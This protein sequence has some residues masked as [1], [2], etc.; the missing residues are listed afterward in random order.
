MLQ[1]DE[2]D[3]IHKVVKAGEDKPVFFD[4]RGRSVEWVAS[5]TRQLVREYEIDV[6][7]FDYLQAFDSDKRHQDRRNQVSYIAR[8]LTDVAKLANISGIIFSQITISE[9]RQYPDKNS[10]K[11]SKDVGNAAE[12]VVMG[13]TA[14]KQIMRR[15]GSTLIEAGERALNLDKNKSGPKGM[16]PVRWD[17]NSACFDVSLDPEV[18]RYQDITGGAFDNYGDKPTEYGNGY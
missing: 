6:V 13:F 2:H 17:A 8:A 11:E 3:R 9:G 18:Q 12:I 4:A 14:A 1:P 7:A 5:R 10:I 16:F 15:D